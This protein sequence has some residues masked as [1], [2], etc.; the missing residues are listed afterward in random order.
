M[1]LGE[2]RIHVSLD[3]RARLDAGASVWLA[4]APEQL[5]VF[6][7]D[8]GE[9]LPARIAL[10]TEGATVVDWPARSARRA[11]KVSEEDR[12]DG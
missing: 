11:K 7:R 2:E 10:A 12:H 5:H 3:G 9:R 6:D 4:V 1:R 8:S